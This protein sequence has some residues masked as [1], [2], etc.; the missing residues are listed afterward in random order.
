[1]MN[2]RRTYFHVKSRVAQCSGDSGFT[3]IEVLLASLAGA[4]ILASVYGVFTGAVK[5][6]D[7]ATERAH[8]AQL[9]ERAERV[10]RTDLANAYISGGTL[11]SALEGS[12]RGPESRFPGFLRFTTTT[13]KDSENEIRGDVQQVSYY[14]VED[15]D[16]PN[17]EA[18]MLV[19]AIDRTL[20]ARVRE[21]AREEDLL[22]NVA[23]FEVSF[24]DGSNWTDTWNYT[25]IATGTT[26]LTTTG[27]NSS[28]SSAARS[29]SL[30][31]EAIRVRITQVASS[32]KIPTPPP[33]EILVPLEAQPFTSGTSATD[34]SSSST[35]PSTA[36]STDTSTGDEEE[37]IPAQQEGEIAGEPG[38]AVG[39]ES[40]DD[41]T[42]TDTSNDQT[43][44]GG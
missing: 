31:P 14:V 37:Y 1:M 39:A 5:T 23:S 17:Q 41:M 28:S 43:T 10:L 13:G 12:E 2:A 18:G 36:V 30:L 25:P 33:M 24:F 34:A 9:R 40:E 3:L 42:E 32:D 29:S 22:P 8:A 27:T 19:R 26:V 20:L 6:R 21:N 7:K 38:V 35:M 44:G 16:N 15:P 11:G 4:M